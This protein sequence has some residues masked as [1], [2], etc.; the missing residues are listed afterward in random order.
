ML[1]DPHSKPFAVSASWDLDRDTQPK[2]RRPRGRHYR[3]FLPP[4]PRSADPA[5]HLAGVHNL[6]WNGYRRLSLFSL[7]S[8]VFFD[9]VFGREGIGELTY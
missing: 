6:W 1:I 5:L 4:P 8:M 9:G 7:C 2:Y 3:G